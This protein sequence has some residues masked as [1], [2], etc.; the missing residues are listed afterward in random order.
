VVTR[1]GLGPGMSIVASSQM[2]SRISPPRA[3]NGYPELAEMPHA[4]RLNLLIEE[5]FH[6]LFDKGYLRVLR[7]RPS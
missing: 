5:G 3:E 1:Q 6:F 4:N 7:F 2:R